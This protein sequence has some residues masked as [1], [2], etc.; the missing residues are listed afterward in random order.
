MAQ[1]QSP[2]LLQYGLA[3]STNSTSCHKG[4]VQLWFWERWRAWLQKL[5]G[6]WWLIQDIKSCYAF[7]LIGAMER[8]MHSTT[9]AHAHTQAC[10]LHT[11]ILICCHWKYW[12]AIFTAHILTNSNQKQNKNNARVLFS[13]CGK[14]QLWEKHIRFASM[15]D[16]LHYILHSNFNIFNI[17]AYDILW[18]NNRDIDWFTRDI[19]FK[20]SSE[21]TNGVNETKTK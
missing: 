2:S 12:F 16:V 19:S 4:L 6:D 14:T 8:N 21:C 3:K 10:T 18:L 1:N 15:L 9:F 20:H 7:S 5:V 17:T 13:L 11:W